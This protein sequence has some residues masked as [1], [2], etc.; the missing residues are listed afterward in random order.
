MEMHVS[1]ELNRILN[2]AREEAMRTGAYEIGTDHLMLGL[3]R[4]GDNSA[5]SAL[6]ALGVDLADFK[7]F[8]ESQIF[9]RESVPYSEESKLIFSR[10]ARNTL[11]MSLL[12]ASSC[13]DFQARAQH[14]LLAI[15]RTAGTVCKTYLDIEGIDRESI[16]AY[17]KDIAPQQKKPESAP[18]PPKR[19]IHIVIGK[20]KIYS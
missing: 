17:L 2:Y 9:R 13:G 12:E 3:L 18:V 10:E 1:D 5:C 7:L 6:T 8:V 14:L 16:A 20:P 11:N 15:T 19:I 4:A